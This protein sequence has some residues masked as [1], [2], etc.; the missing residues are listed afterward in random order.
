MQAGQSIA[1]PKRTIEDTP[2]RHQEKKKLVDRLQEMEDRKKNEEY[3]LM[4]DY[5]IFEKKRSRYSPGK[6]GLGGMG[7]ERNRGKVSGKR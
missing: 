3:R 7:S 4:E 2:N 1:F 5:E 6:G